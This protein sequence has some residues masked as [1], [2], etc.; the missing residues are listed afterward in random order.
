MIDVNMQ[1][2]QFKYSDQASPQLF[3]IHFML[4]ICM[5]KS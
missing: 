5:H 1:S 3:N 2:E 4:N